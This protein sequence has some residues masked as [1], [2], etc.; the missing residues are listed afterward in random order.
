MNLAELRRLAE[1]AI[2][3]YERQ[4]CIMAGRESW[5]TVTNGNCVAAGELRRTLANPAT[6]L[7]LLDVVEAA[8][9]FC[10]CFSE[11]HCGECEA[12]LRAALAALESGGGNKR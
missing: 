10:E 11:E 6:L 8:Q 3:H 9:A 12:R 2:P 7:R 1:A 4:Q 5:P